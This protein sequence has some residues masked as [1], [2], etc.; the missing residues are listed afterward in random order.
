LKAAEKR[1]WGV[2]RMPRLVRSDGGARLIL[3]PWD[4][5]YHQRGLDL[6]PGRA[7]LLPPGAAFSRMLLKD[8]VWR[9]ISAEI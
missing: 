8:R 7:I 2:A 1:H 3:A 6:E 5:A 9:P 4:P